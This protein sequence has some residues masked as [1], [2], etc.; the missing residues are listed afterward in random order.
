MFLVYAVNEYRDAA[1]ENPFKKLSDFV[2][3]LLSLPFSNAD[4]ERVFST[5]NFVKNKTRNR[6]KLHHCCM[7]F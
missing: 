5:M 4:V 7:V 6:M 3:K 1:G 2:L